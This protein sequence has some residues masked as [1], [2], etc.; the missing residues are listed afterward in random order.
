[1]KSGLSVRTVMW[2]LLLGGLGG[3]LCFVPLFNLLGFEFSFAI[4]IAAAFAGAHL[5]A[6]V[7]WERRHGASRSD[8][9]GADAHPF[10]TV[11][12]L[13]QNAA[14]RVLLVLLPPL[15]LVSL[16]ALRVRNCNYRAG[17][18][19]YGVLPL[20]SGWLGAAAGVC[21][22]LLGDF[23]RRAVPTVIAF[24]IVIGSILWSAWRFYAA[25]PI[26]AYDP[27]GGYFPGT[28]YD[29]DIAI[30]A[31]LGFARLYHALGAAAAL[32]ACALWLDG[33]RLRLEL[34]AARGRALIA[35]VCSL[36][37]G[38]A[39]LLHARSA[40]L[41]FALDTR[42]V[43]RAL[44]AERTTAHFV[45]H[46]TPAGPW[47]K[48]IALHADDFE[49]RYR[50]LESLLGVVPSGPVHAYLFDSAVHKQSLMGAGHT[51]IA[52]PWRRDIYLQADGW[53][54]PVMMHELAHV[55]AGR[56]G[57]SLF[58]V[59]RRGLAFN[60]GLI[61]GVAVAAA[62]SGTPLTPHQLVKVMRDHKIEPPLAGVMSLRFFGWNP[63]Q[64]YN[65][66]GSFCRH[67]LEKHGA[68]PLRQVFAAGGSADSWQAAYG[69]P[70]ATLASEWSAFIDR[71]E[72]PAGEALM[73][74]ERLRRP[75]VF[76]KVC[77]HELALRREQA[78]RA[79]GEG[80]RARALSTLE[81]VCH[82]DPDEPGNLAEIMDASSDDRAAAERAIARLLAHPKVSAPQRARALSL[83]GDLALRAGDPA[84]AD[85]AYAQAAELPLDEPTAR[86]LTVKRLSTREPPGPV[87]DELRRFLSSPG[88]GRDPALDLVAVSQL[89]Q[90]APQR[91]LFHYLLGRQLESRG[92]AEQA[93][94]ELR[95]GLD[96]LPDERF[97]REALRLLGRAQLR[98]GDLPGCRATFEKLRGPEVPE[99]LR[100]EA[101]DY[102][103]RCAS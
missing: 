88:S 40:R 90:A 25:P 3:A 46:Y 70:F 65:V 76:H 36:L 89:V 21:A 15:L 58:G 79:L 1:M 14:G 98:S 54:H 86:L 13:W 49:L 84:A 67:L 29:E 73:M 62:W 102:L 99:G 28:L 35:L 82:D 31:P 43:Q 48:E 16:N 53:P 2:A 17:L 72:V 77:A 37:A 103:A 32:A 97:V 68:A 19:W 59:S 101:A 47:A 22:G 87:T 4:G 41:G 42:D 92:R 55:F 60:V 24:A 39:F 50:Q 34:R 8:R 33:G 30:R 5:G 56:F 52:K 51:F 83:R 96:G 81:S 44:G 9:D 75:S 45:L 94:S 66:A 85:A 26:F 80:D 27:F 78:R 69:R 38:G 10:S 23:R 20:A 71:V 95:A 61:E 63:T 100:L 18:E 6:A 7:V 64:A 11:R 93:I 74:R 12:S 91:G 57:D